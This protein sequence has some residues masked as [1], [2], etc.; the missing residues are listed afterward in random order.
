VIS[1]PLSVVR[2]P[3]GSLKVLKIVAQC[4]TFHCISNLNHSRFSCA[5]TRQPFWLEN[6]SLPPN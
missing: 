4:V 6:F 3:D 2:K 5:S 1:D